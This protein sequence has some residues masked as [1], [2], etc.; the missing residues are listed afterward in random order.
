MRRPSGTWVMPFCTMSWGAIDRS[1]VWSSRTSPVLGASRP[2]SA[3]SVVVLPAPLLPSSVTIS[4]S[5]TLNDT[6]FK[7]WISP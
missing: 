7:A 2:E 3:R 6:P 1:E 4:P 5:A